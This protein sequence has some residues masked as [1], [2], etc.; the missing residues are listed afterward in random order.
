MTS[1]QSFSASAPL[2]SNRLD[3][4]HSLAEVQQMRQSVGDD[5]KRERMIIADHV[6]KLVSPFSS[7]FSSTSD[8]KDGN[9]TDTFSVSSLTNGISGWMGRISLVLSLFEGLKLG[10]RF[11]R[12]I[13]KIFA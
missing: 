8:N 9:E 3:L 6:R 7:H 5:I 11:F 10:I 1:P 12:R 4:C 2:K 13:R